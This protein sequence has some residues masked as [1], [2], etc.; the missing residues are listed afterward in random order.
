M[1]TQRA[2]KKIQRAPIL[3]KFDRHVKTLCLTVGFG[4]YI[5]Q[6]IK[7]IPYS[8]LL[9]VSNRRN[10]EIRKLGQRAIAALNAAR[11]DP[12]ILVAA[13]EAMARWAENPEPKPA[14]R[15]KPPKPPKPPRE[16]SMVEK[17]KTNLLLRYRWI[18]MC[19]KVLAEDCGYRTRQSYR[20]ELTLLLG[21]TEPG[22]VI[23]PEYLQ[24]T[25]DKVY[26]KLQKR[27]EK[28]HQFSSAVRA[29]MTDPKW[30]EDDRALYD[31]FLFKLN[32]FDPTWS[33]RTVYNPPGAFKNPIKRFDGLHVMGLPEYEV[34]DPIWDIRRDE[35]IYESDEIT[36][37]AWYLRS[38]PP[39]VS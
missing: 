25:F 26:E 10:L 12:R 15:P 17:C 29:K 19:N 32:E 1:P 35:A 39:P 7:D 18:A 27:P 31:A 11:L 6:R 20:R 37:T 30:T 14:P 33:P 2:T 22:E 24:P 13:D 3:T 9:W 28:Y 8:Y 38:S 34:I 4:K 21:H 23:L 36:D 16:L 5:T